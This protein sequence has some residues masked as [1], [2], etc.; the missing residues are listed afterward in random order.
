MATSVAVI[1]AGRL[2]TALAVALEESGY[3][4]AAVLARR[5]ARARRAASFLSAETLA[6]GSSQL[7]LVPPVDILLV[8]TP[9][10]SIA[11]TAAHLAE[12]LQAAPRLRRVALHTSGA[13]SSEAL[14]P[15]REKGLAVGSMHPLVSVSDACS[16]AESLR[17]AFF[18]TE[19]DR[20]AV[21]AARGIVRALG[22]QSFTI[23][24]EDKALYHAAAVMTSGH[25]VSLFQTATELLARC[26]L[27]ETRSRRILLPLL[28]STLENLSTQT[29]ARALTGTFARGD[30]STVRKHLSALRSTEDRD[31]LELYALLGRRALPLAEENGADSSALG[32]IARLLDEVLNG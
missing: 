11:E 31:A 16:G 23:K 12:T 24:T 22:A 7:G 1:G 4:V 15:L 8:T 21:R 10:D 3:R 13:L 5:A 17:R 18:C 32:E 20:A 14:A 27:D 2:G 29:P 25:T 26:G 6:L 9:D 30:V 28:G 19:G